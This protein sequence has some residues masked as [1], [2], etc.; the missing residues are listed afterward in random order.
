MSVETAENCDVELVD[1]QLEEI[2]SAF[3][4]YS[5]FFSVEEAPQT[6][7]NYLMQVEFFGSPMLHSVSELGYDVRAVST[8]NNEEA[9]DGV[10]VAV[11]L[12]ESEE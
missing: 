5:D 2:E 12:V 8:R 9:F 7:A 10:A 11:Y 1:E 6:W 3:S 4:I